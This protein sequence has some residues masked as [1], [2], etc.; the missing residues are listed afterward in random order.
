MQVS[1]QEFERRMKQISEEKPEWLPRIRETNDLKR[2][3]QARTAATP[4]SAGL[5]PRTTEELPG[6][7]PTARG[8]QPRGSNAS[9]GAR[10]AGTG[11][12][13]REAPKIPVAQDEEC[14]CN[15]CA[16]A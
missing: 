8:S 11:R 1:A 9:E 3:S 15:A 2:P 6:E 16:I 12:P 5:Q 4:G 7:R 14:K 13:S 10:V